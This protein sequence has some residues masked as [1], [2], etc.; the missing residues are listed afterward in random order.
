MYGTE[1]ITLQGNTIVYDRQY[2]EDDAWRLTLG[3]KAL[4]DGSLRHPN[5]L[6]QLRRIESPQFAIQWQI[7]RSHPGIIYII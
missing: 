5:A 6:S 3:Y 4:R 7:Q 2:S 1:K